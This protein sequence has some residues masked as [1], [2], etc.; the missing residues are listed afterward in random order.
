MRHTPNPNQPFQ[1]PLAA[2]EAGFIY[3]LGIGGI[4]MSALARYLQMAG[5]SVCGYDKTETDLTRSLQEIGIEVHYTDDVLR[6]PTDLQLVIYT[7]AVPTDLHLY[8]YCLQSGKPMKKRSEVLQA[9]TFGTYNICVA[10]THGKTTTSTLIAHILRH[11]GYGCQAYLGGISVNYQTNTWS[12]TRN[13]SVIEADEYDRSFLRLHP[14]LAL[15]TAMDP[16]HLDIYGTVQAMEEAYI[17]FTRLLS[18]QGVLIYH[19]SLKQ[20]A[21]LEAPTRFSYALQVE[22]ADYYVCSLAAAADG[23]QFD[24]KIPGGI[25]AGCSLPIGGLHNVENAVGA[26]AVCHRLGIGSEAIRSA[27]ACFQGVKRRFETLYRTH[28]RRW[29]DDY[30]HHP[31]E[32]RALLLGIR[33]LYPTHYLTL[34]FQPHLYT[35]TR[36]L[37]ADF[38]EV[39]SLAD[40]SYLLPIYPARELPIEGVSSEMIRSEKHPEG[41]PVW[42]K[43]TF[44]NW[45]SNQW[46]YSTPQPGI[47]VTAGAG[48]IDQ[49]YSS[50]LKQLPTP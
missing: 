9:L 46:S 49:L 13:V 27:L 32:L 40:Q 4:G 5:Y 42:D 10:G 47:L 12:S 35:R 1:F 15:I 16:D 2:K 41:Y 19:H 23:Y 17:D 14:D 11:S 3:F 39:L 29:I 21:A 38:A 22:T 44:A 31:E 28:G 45:V 30:A 24:L 18:D 43:Q 20:A 8:Q 48:D 34:V 36:D 50:I 37:A 26:A 33:D 6:I 7:P 25:I